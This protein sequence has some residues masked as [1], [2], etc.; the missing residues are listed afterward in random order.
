MGNEHALAGLVT[1][2]PRFSRSVSLPRDWGRDDSLDG[3]ILTPSG[4]DILGRFA[5]SLRGESP[6]RAWSLTGPYGSGKSAFSLF[7]SQLLGGKGTAGE[8]ARDLLKENDQKLWK[9]L[10]Q[11]KTPLADDGALCPIL[12]TGSR[13]PLEGSLAGGVLQGLRR[14]FPRLPRALARQLEELSSPA[15][16]ANRTTALVSAFEEVI[17]FVSLEE[18]GYRGLLLVVDELGKFLEYAASHPEEGD[19]FVLQALAEAASRSEKPFLL[20]TVLHQAIDRYTAHISQGRRQEW[21]KVQGRFEDI[22]FEEPTEQ[23]LRLMALALEHSGPEPVRRSLEQTGR[24]LAAEAWSLGARVGG[25]EK[26]E[27][28]DLLAA[29]APLHP[30]V[31]LILGPL[32][33]RLAQN[34]RSLF[35]FLSSGEPFAF[36]DFLRTVKWSKSGGEVYRLDQLYDYVTTALGGALYSQHRGKYWAEVQSVLERLHE[37]NPLEVRVAKAIGLVQALGYSAGLPASREVLRFAFRGDGVGEKDVDAAIAALEGLSA[38]VYRRHAGSYALW[39]GSDVNIEA[40]LEEA[41]RAVDPGRTL[42]AYLAELAQPRPLIAR[43]HSLKT[44]T[45]RYFDVAYADRAALSGL[46][47]KDFGDADGRVIYC[48]PL[49][50]DDRAAME[51]ELA[52]GLKDRPAVIA[53]LPKELF[54]LK[55]ACQELACLRWVAQNTPDLGGDAT[56]RRELRARL[57]AAESALA[58]ELRR[59][60]VPR[61]A[62]GQ[63]CRWFHAGAEVPA[64]SPRELN[65]LLS[66]VA[67]RVYPATP[68]WRNE[69]VNR[70]SL[71]SSAAA[72][73]RTL[74]EAMIERHDREGL[75]IEGNPPERSMYESLLRASGLHRAKGGKWGFNRPLPKS[76]PALDTVWKAV[77]AFFAESVDRRRPVGELFRLLSRPPYGLKEGVLPVLFAAALLYYDTEAALY[78]E[79]T[80]IPSLSIAVFERMIH[81]P[82]RFEVQYCRIS[83]PRAVVFSRYASMLTRTEESDESPRPQLLTVVRPLVRFVRQLPEFV[84][85]TQQLSASAKAVFQAIR[86]AREPDQLL[87]VELPRACEAE[88]FSATGPAESQQADAFFGKLR[89][90]LAELQQAYP[91]LQAS[92]EQMVLKAFSLAG[93]LAQ[94]REELMHRA[95]LVSE[96]SVDQKLK[97][98]VTRILDDPG[99][100]MTWLESV[101]ALLGG[102]P[103]QAWNDQERA[104]FEVNLA[105]MAR[106]FKHFEALAFEMER[107]GAALLDG[108]DQ[109]IRVAV[110]VPH[111]EELE[112]VVRIPAKLSE[113]AGRAQDGI[114]KALAEA[115]VLKDRELSVAILAQVVRQML[116]EQER[117]R[118]KPG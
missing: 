10:F 30:T 40:R 66:N 5:A 61:D 106:T 58:D 81:A 83:G 68:N 12:I 25:F 24:E 44:G 22:A 42:S 114:R 23:I 6:T 59:V 113:Q 38:V 19:V 64:R 74:I 91:K 27:F 94:A 62:D 84:G 70:R 111:S 13:E 28:V 89:L 29:C 102:K 100:D 49:H 60:F 32:F 48:L 101:A 31:A 55:E 67:D 47:D 9:R 11:G 92:I 93:P 50:P 39:E 34:E 118:D 1:V 26:R 46:L 53:A 43:R 20:V 16:K 7:L 21:A 57:G 45:L 77:E 35:A 90:A 33:R 54:D 97:A 4:R 3:Y 17:E 71:S 87:F 37:A 79:G 103:P 110:T 117:G 115:G 85:N 73:R 69:L 109:A 65:A 107:A 51:A 14:L 95:R 105:L 18:T 8:R 78:E 52:S 2:R 72:A 104:R 63:H 56:A 98:L 82:E 15:E 88:P 36:Q 76:D 116:G 41:R 99:D 96:L 112:R 86:E 80:F 75:S 108:D